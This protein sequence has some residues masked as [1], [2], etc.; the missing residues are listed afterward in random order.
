MSVSDETPDSGLHRSRLRLRGS[1]R[2]AADPR[3]QTARAVLSMVDLLSCAFGGALFLFILTA[4]P[5]NQAGGLPPAATDRA[6]LWIDIDSTTARPIVILKRFENEGGALQ[7]TIRVDASRLKGNGSLREVVGA[8]S[9]DTG[10]KISTFGLTPWEVDPGVRLP[11][12]VL[13]LDDPS[14]FW[15]VRLGVASDDSS[16]RARSGTAIQTGQMTVRKQS[17]GSVSVEDTGDVV[18]PTGVGMA[19]CLALRF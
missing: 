4:A 16:A 5:A 12:L 11:T 14:S 17:V 10:G 18:E 9:N 19:D 2:K 13:M 8:R 6:F 3:A 15:C 1:R 7:D